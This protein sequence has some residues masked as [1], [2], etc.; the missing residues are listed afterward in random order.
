MIYTIRH[1]TEADVPALLQLAEAARQI[2]RQSGNPTQW[3]NG[4]PKAEDFLRD[5]DRQGSFVVLRGEE[6]VGTFAFLSGPD[7]T[8]AKIYEGEW[9]DDVQPYHVVHRIASLPEAHGVMRVLLDYCFSHSHNIRIDTHRDNTIM[10][11]LLQRFGFTYCGIIFL[12]NGQERL[13]YQRL[14]LKGYPEQ[15]Y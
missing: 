3:I 15:G 14:N 6:P 5:I 10:R 11:H 1:A 7:P 4:Y 2:M 8:Y 9:L 13:A 12:A